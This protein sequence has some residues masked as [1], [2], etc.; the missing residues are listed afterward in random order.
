MKN[1]IKSIAA[2]LIGGLLGG[3][4]T[5]QIIKKR[6]EQRLAAEMDILKKTFSQKTKKPKEKNTSKEANEVADDIT[7]RLNARKKKDP[8]DYTSF[9]KSSNDNEDE[10]TVVEEELKTNAPVE[11]LPYVV[12]PAEFESTN[13]EQRWLT[14]YA[15]DNVLADEND[16]KVDI[17]S[18]IGE[19]A[20]KRFGEYESD[21]VY[22][23]NDIKETVYE[24]SR[25]PKAFKEVTGQDETEDED[26]ED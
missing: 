6:F 9:Y 21:I 20:L 26:E 15:G 18:T 23:K 7:S 2:F 10:E 12:T 3:C 5:Y 19:S 17:S 24:V 1:G 8:I 11:S 4:I 16:E 25:N 14:Y 22:V 13:F